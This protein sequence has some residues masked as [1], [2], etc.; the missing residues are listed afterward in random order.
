VAGGLLT[1]AAQRQILQRFIR[2]LDG[3]HRTAW[4]EERYRRD[5]TLASA[6]AVIE[7]RWS[8]VTAAIAPFLARYRLASGILLPV[9]GLGPDGRF[10][11]GERGGPAL[12]AVQLPRDPARAEDAAFF[13]VRELCYPAV[14]LALDAPGI[15]PADRAAAE[16]LSGRAAV[17]CGS[18]VLGTASPDLARAYEAAFLH[19]AGTSSGFTTAF[20]VPDQVMAALARAVAGIR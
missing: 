1:T 14:R 3:E 18:L 10:V 2:A 13:A 19:A 9:P 4:R 12:V 5:S 17:R 20:P 8:A 11:A 6:R 15:V 16:V 7:R